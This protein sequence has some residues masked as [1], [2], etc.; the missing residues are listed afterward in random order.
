MTQPAKNQLYLKVHPYL[1][2]FYRGYYGSEIIDV[3]DNPLLSLRIK[4]ILQTRAESHYRR[5][6][7]DFRIIVLNLPYFQVGNKRINVACR[8]HLDDH[9]QFLISQELYQDFK[10]M[11][12]NFVLGYVKNGGLQADAIRDFCDFYNFEM[13]QVKTESLKKM[14]DRSALKQKWNIERGVLKDVK[15]RPLKITGVSPSVVQ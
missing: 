12:L 5:K 7:S 2:E 6:W 9:R 13:N 3:K 14:W 11:F 15:L 4:S 1:W 8:K 10:N